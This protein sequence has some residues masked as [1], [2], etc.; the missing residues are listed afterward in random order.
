MELLEPRIAPAGFEIINPIADVVLGAGQD[1]VT[2]ELSH[3]FD[4]SIL[5]PGHT[6]VTFTLN[7]DSDPAT[8]GLQMDFDLAT[9][10]DQP[11]RIVFELFDDDAPLTV[12]NF[13][14]YVE[15]PNTAADYL[16]TFIHR[17]IPGFVIQGGGWNAASTEEHLESFGPIHNEFSPLHSNVAGTLAMA[18]NGR[19]GPH[20]A[21]NEWFIN[22]VDNSS[23]LDVQNGGFAVFGRVIEGM[24]IVNKIAA[25]STVD[26]GG[27]FTNL[28]VQNF[29][30]P[31]SSSSFPAADNLVTIMDTSVVRPHERPV[32][33]GE[34]VVDNLTITDNEGRPSGAVTGA[35]FGSALQLSASGQSG[36]ANVSF[37]ATLGGETVTETFTVRHLPNLTPSISWEGFLPITLPGDS[38]KSIITVRNTG[39]GTFSGTVILKVYLSPITSDDPSGLLRTDDDIL[40]GEV[41]SLGPNLDGDGEFV[42]PDVRLTLPDSLLPGGTGKGC[43]FIVEA[44]PLGGSTEELFTDDNTGSSFGTH[45]FVNHFGT[46]EIPGFVRKNAMLSYTEPDG[47]KV[48]FWIKGRGAGQIEYLEPASDEPGIANLTITGTDKHS[49]VKVRVEKGFVDGV[50]SDGRVDL[51]NIEVL[52][53][54]SALRLGAAHVT[55]DVNLRRGIGLLELGDLTGD[56]E[57]EITIGAPLS[58]G[59]TKVRL[60][61][62]RDYSLTSQQ[63]IASLTAEAWHNTDAIEDDISAFRLSSLKTTG[64]PGNVLGDFEANLTVQT[65]IARINIAGTV[66][67]AEIAVTG[68]IGRVVADAVVD[69]VI[70]V[71]DGI[72]R[73]KLGF[74]GGSA[75]CAGITPEALASELPGGSFDRFSVIGSIKIGTIQD[76]LVGASKIGSVMIQQIL[77][78][79]G[80]MGSGFR[81]QAIGEYHRAGEIH[82]SNL[83]PGEV[84]DEVGDYYVRVVQAS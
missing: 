84:Y 15:N 20:S 8:P 78:A 44:E 49:E 58:A 71:D 52:N 60:G 30:S 13:L 41:H 62:V 66:R 19:F 68:A 50:I 3:L 47:D 5:Y 46:I 29:T 42:V 34:I 11:A 37:T 32:S 59:K 6:I 65:N 79:N 54:I 45:Y 33:M 39:S 80:G 9:P 43:R 2:I 26:R 74:L 57:T 16:S 82:L 73:M 63:D 14:R 56:S 75:I 38:A 4:P 25:L 21:T 70:R 40:V 64:A 67:E 12:Q 1:G 31:P 35:F 18:S 23:N 28:P 83:K 10:G 77:L 72:G 22:L 76:S 7:L 81:A 17:S 51:S 24:D 48:T 61:V 27:A 36:V 69:S 53:S 55:G